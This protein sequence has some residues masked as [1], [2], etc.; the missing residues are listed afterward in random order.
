MILIGALS[1]LLLAL[2][3]LA[4]W[5]LGDQRADRAAMARLVALQPVAPPEFSPDMVADLPEPARRYFAFAIAPGTPLWTVAQ[6]DMTGRFALGDKAEPN[7]IDMTAAQVLAAPQGFV[8]RMSGARGAMRVAGSD[9]G[10][11]T[12]FW[13]MGVLPV[14][15]AGAD[16]NL[17][18]SAF[19]RMAAEA[20]FWTPAALLPGPDVTWQAVDAHTARVTLRRGDLEQAVDLTVDDD[21]RPQQVVFA[22]WTNA[23][24]DRAWREQ[25]FGGTLDGFR[26]FGGYRLPTHVE[27]GNQF[28]TDGYF[29]FFIAQVTDIRFPAPADMAGP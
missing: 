24:P 14:A 11:W 19:G 9:S 23:N 7:Y 5:R 25:P 21:G 2:A 29:P 6:I 12:R 28:G 27:A 20:V 16:D 3:V 13:A 1:V 8:W 15:R 22:R 10:L 17:R 18:R 4:L 26:D